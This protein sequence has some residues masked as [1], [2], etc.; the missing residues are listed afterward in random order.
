MAYLF[1]RKKTIALQE[2]GLLSMDPMG[3]EASF[4]VVPDVPV[5]PLSIHGTYGGSWQFTV[6]G[7]SVTNRLPKRKVLKQTPFA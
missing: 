2:G 6:S 4:P 1:M 7:I 5:V 3:K